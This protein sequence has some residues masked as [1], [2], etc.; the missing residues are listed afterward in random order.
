VRLQTV[1][2]YP[3]VNKSGD[4]VGPNPTDRAKRGVKKSLLV[5][6]DGGP[7]SAA[8]APANRPDHQLL[9]QTIEAIV[10]ERPAPE[11]DFQ[12][13]LARDKAF[14]ND[15]GYLAG[16]DHDYTPPIAA[17]RA[18]VPPKPKRYPARR[19]VVERMIAWLNHHR[20]ILIRWEQ[21]A[22][23]YLGFLQLAC[24]LLWYRRSHR[25]TAT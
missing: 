25:L 10:L 19:W 3:Q 9:R 24:S 17:I 18:E 23:N 6:A 4:Q 20:A 13:H 22:T 7:L 16:I 5:E 15:E 14:D 11:P 21:K 1:P 2:A 12:Q 8:V